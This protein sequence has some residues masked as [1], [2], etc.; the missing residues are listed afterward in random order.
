MIAFFEKAKKILRHGLALQEEAQSPEQSRLIEAIANKAHEHHL[1]FPL[2]AFVEGLRPAATIASSL[3]IG[4]EP[5]AEIFVSRNDYAKLISF[6]SN[7]E[8]LDQLI[9][10]LESQPFP[11]NGTTSH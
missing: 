7:R 3:L 5:F 6:V 9:T 11:G 4:L 8:N 2:L 1:T 10:A